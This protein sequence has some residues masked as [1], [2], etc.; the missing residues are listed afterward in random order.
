MARVEDPS[1]F[2]KKLKAAIKL[3]VDS[4]TISAE[5]KKAIQE[6]YFSLRRKNMKISTQITHINTLKRTCEHIL[7][8]GIIKPLYEIDLFDYDRLLEFL[9]TEMGYKTGTINQCK[10]SIRSFM[11]WKYGDGVPSWVL[12]EVKMVHAPTPVQPQDLPTREEFTEFLEAAPHPRD[13]AI[14]AVC[15][16]GGIRIGAL[17]ACCTNS[18]TETPHGVVLY[19]SKTGAN[20]TTPAK[21]VPLTWSAGYLQQWLAIHPLRNDP[22][23]PLWTTLRRIRQPNT[24]TLQYEALSYEGACYVFKQV[25]KK[26]DKSKHVHP[27]TLRHYAVTCWIL[28]GLRE[29]DI[30]YRA[31]WTKD[32]KQMFSTYGNFADDDMNMRIFEH[33]G[34]KTDDRRQIVLKKCPRCNNVLKPEDRFCSQCSLV[35]SND[36]F[37]EVQE[38]KNDLIQT[39]RYAMEDPEFQMKLI[40]ISE[41]KKK[42][43]K[44]VITA[45]ISPN[46]SL[47]CHALK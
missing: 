17:L 23:A 42:R 10:K 46:N 33:Y 7:K 37:Q 1:N 32:S 15:A 6:F 43:T 30:N 27:H 16:D 35:L 36:A 45:R 14:I 38:Q 22:N 40:A 26:L 3:V 25:E 47:F 11:K 5:D 39:L 34:L 29:Q 19:L 9:E 41:E 2:E 31:G 13:K 4:E 44:V 8:I 24:G 21:G 20:K 18:V 12:N 28:D